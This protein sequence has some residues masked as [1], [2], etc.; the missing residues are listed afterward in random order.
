LSN[1]WHGR[2]N[3]Q[4]QSQGPHADPRTPSDFSA[5][6]VNETTDCAKSPIDGDY[7]NQ[8]IRTCSDAKRGEGANRVGNQENRPVATT[9][10]TNQFVGQT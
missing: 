6:P 5:R 1:R 3:E 4:E 7:T 10:V 9:E 8:S 2:A